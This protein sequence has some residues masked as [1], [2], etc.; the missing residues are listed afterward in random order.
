LD[1][2]SD[3]EI[4][5][6]KRKTKRLKE[7]SAARKAKKKAITRKYIDSD[8]EEETR[9]KKGITS[10]KSTPPKQN[11]QQEVEDLIKQLNTMS[12]DDPGYGF[13]Y[14]KAIKLDRDVE[15]V[16]RRPLNGT[17]NQNRL[18]GQN[19]RR[20]APPH[21]TNA[22]PQAGGGGF[23][24]RPPMRCFGCGE[25]GHG[26]TNC[27]KTNELIHAGVL[28]HD[29]A[30]QIVRGD[31]TY[32]HRISLDEPFVTAVE[33]ERKAKNPQSN[34]VTFAE[35]DKSY[36]LEEDEKIREDETDGAWIRE[37][38]SEGETEHF[39]YLVDTGRRAG[40]KA[41]RKKVNDKVYPEP[42]P[43]GVAKGKPRMNQPPRSNEN[44]PG[45]SDPSSHRYGTRKNM[46][47]KENTLLENPENIKMPSPVNPKPRS[48]VKDK[49]TI[50]ELVPVTVRQ[51]EWDPE[52]EDS[53]IED[54]A[55][56]PI[57]KEKQQAPAP[58]LQDKTND[59][60][61]RLM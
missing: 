42:L 21:M 50:P 10:V 32:L 22:Q 48:P 55:T 44:D 27:Q 56:Y 45:T 6:L 35:P 37:M 24:P 7:L 2:D 20:D 39:V 14:F 11:N 33:R 34:L 52:D 31:G 29:N 38:D 26:V 47:G 17:Q 41:A 16:V 28:A 30:G 51:K 53:M 5:H 9:P 18:P 4:K 8:D 13:A 40:A 58:P 25:L 1:E 36:Y 23:M 59:Q 57:R 12:L 43:P 15:K 61:S 60:P 49:E 3:N 54:E 19:M 46:Q